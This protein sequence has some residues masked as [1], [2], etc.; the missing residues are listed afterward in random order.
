MPLSP[1]QKTLLT[2]IGSN[3]RQERINAGLTQGRLAELAELDIRTVQ[4]I[5][6]AELNLLI[7][8]VARLREALRCRWENL[9]GK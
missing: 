7:T 3:V 5:E 1:E 6:A 2:R 8:T 9:L 4:K